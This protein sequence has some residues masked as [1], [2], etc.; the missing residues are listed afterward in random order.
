MGWP[1]ISENFDFLGHTNVC[2]YVC[3]VCMHVYIYHGMYVCVY[4]CMHVYRYV[5]TDIHILS[6]N[7]HNSICV[8]AFGYQCRFIHV[9]LFYVGLA[10][11]FPIQKIDRLL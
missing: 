1:I 8:C 5:Y 7:V 4:V 6:L 9:S 3:M 10:L 2:M 11:D